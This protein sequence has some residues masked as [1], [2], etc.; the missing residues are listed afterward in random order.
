MR[1][2]VTPDSLVEWDGGSSQERRWD[3]RA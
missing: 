2:E 1:F 3:R